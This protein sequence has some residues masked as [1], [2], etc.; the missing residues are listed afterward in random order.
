M[1]AL[2]TKRITKEKNYMTHENYKTHPPLKIFCDHCK[3]DRWSWEII[4]QWPLMWQ[5]QTPLYTIHDCH[6]QHMQ[7]D[8][9]MSPFMNF[10]LFRLP[11]C[12][13]HT[14]QIVVRITRASC[15]SPE[16][17]VCHTRM[18]HPYGCIVFGR[19]TNLKIIF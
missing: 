17:P 3:V 11:K 18:L 5:K 10:S 1:Y 6:M 9:L 4:P 7:K 14:V 16:F 12:K 8:T 19:R 13:V 15:S 2:N